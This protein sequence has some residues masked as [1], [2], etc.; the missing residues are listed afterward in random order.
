MTNPGPTPLELTDEIKQAVNN[1]YDNRTPMVVV[2]VDEDGQPSMSMR[3]TV[4]AWSDTQLAF[5]ARTT[6]NLPSALAARPRVTLWYRD[7]ATRTTLQFRGTAKVDGDES[8][9]NAVFDAS[10]ANEQAADPERKGVAVLVDLDR[11]DGRTPA[12]PVAMA[13]DA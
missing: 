7:P 13:K 4:S 2:Y 1:A 3:G 12:G 8:F 10:P 11:V 6:S 9:R 5:W